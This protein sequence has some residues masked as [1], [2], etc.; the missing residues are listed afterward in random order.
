AGSGP[1]APARPRGPRTGAGPGPPS[2]GSSGTAWAWISRWPPRCPRRTPGRSRAPGT[3]RS[4]R[5][6]PRRTCAAA[7]VRASLPGPSRLDRDRL[8]RD[9]ADE[10]A[11]LARVRRARAWML[12]HARMR[13]ATCAQVAGDRYTA[14]RLGRMLKSYAKELAEEPDSPLYFG[15]L[16][17]GD[18]P[19]AD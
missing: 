19:D 10:L 3:A 12:D 1:P 7:C 16:R 4:R 8:D 6:T 11:F 18:G 15:R 5:P 9:F 17:F 14:E 2:T 13:V